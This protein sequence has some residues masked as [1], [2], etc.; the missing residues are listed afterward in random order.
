MLITDFGDMEEARDW[1]EKIEAESRQTDR[2]A[3]TLD[4]Q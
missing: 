4:F 1:K 2:T 3:N